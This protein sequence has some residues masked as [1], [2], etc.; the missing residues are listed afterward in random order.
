MV[1]SLSMDF[2]LNDANRSKLEKMELDRKDF[3]FRYTFQNILK[4]PNIETSNKDTFSTRVFVNYAKQGTNPED[5]FRSIFLC[6]LRRFFPLASFDNLFVEG[7][8]LM[9]YNHVCTEI[10]EESYF[11]IETLQALFSQETSID[12]CGYLHPP[13]GEKELALYD[14]VG[15]TFMNYVHRTYGSRGIKNLLKRYYSASSAQNLKFSGHNLSQHCTLWRSY[16]K[17]Q[18]CETSKS[19]GAIKFLVKLILQL[20][21]S[22]YLLFPATVVFIG[23]DIGAFVYSALT[24]ATI[25]Y[26]IALPTLP[27]RNMSNLTS[28]SLVYNFESQKPL[29]IA[30]SILI[31]INFGLVLTDVIINLLLSYMATSY[32]SKHRRAVFSSLHS[33]DASHSQGF[34]SAKLIHLYGED[35]DTI[36]QVISTV[37]VFLGR[38]IFL[39]FGGTLVGIFIHYTYILFFI[40]S[41]VIIYIM[42]SSISF[43]LRKSQAKQSALLSALTHRIQD[44]FD[45][46]YETWH[47]SLKNYWLRSIKEKMRYSNYT[48]ILWWNYSI[49]RI[50][51]Y[52]IS[53]VNAIFMILSFTIPAFLIVHFDFSFEKSLAALIIFFRI[54]R[55]PRELVSM[56]DLVSKGAG[57]YSNLVSFE[58]L[59]SKRPEKKD[60]S[61]SQSSLNSV[62]EFRPSIELDGVYLSRFHGFGIWSLFD[63]NLNIPYGQRVAIVGASG[64]GKSS[65][66]NIILGFLNP[67]RGNLLIHDGAYDFKP[68]SS[69]LYGV[70]DQFNHAFNLTINDNLKI[71]NLGASNQDVVNACESVSLH[72]WVISLPLEYDSLLHKYGNNMSGGQRQRLA[73]AQA[74]LADVSV[75]VADECTSSLDHE[76]AL[77]IID[78]LFRVTEGRTLIFATN[79]FER[80]ETF[81]VIHVVSGGRVVESGPYSELM[82]RMEVFYTLY[83]EDSPA[84]EI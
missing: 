38:F 55:S 36:E 16:L 23:I 37:F 66:L 70:V 20:L 61:K 42:G 4:F 29:I 3:V 62:K 60:L 52:V 74:I 21:C 9:I 72:P 78:T 11:K 71:A 6:D 84:S 39:L 40:L 13:E 35:I 24:E 50:Y 8:F 82:E 79:R 75:L 17:N 47:Y 59:N 73:I 27:N 83:S 22:H 57:A 81:D 54:V 43:F 64:S 68:R 58:K 41:Y 33:M 56:Y 63:I 76:T 31:G 14:A 2:D 53:Q 69:G 15:F 32:G 7:L 19:Y 12:L 28:T 77:Q 67:T 45:G 48:S 25:T 44:M 30:C 34:S 51:T 1:D 49:S 18:T 10:G 26:L 65:I 80:L 5:Y 46:F